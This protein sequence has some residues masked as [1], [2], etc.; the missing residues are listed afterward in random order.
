MEAEKTDWQKFKQWIADTV[1]FRFIKN[2]ILEKDNNNLKETIGWF[3]GVTIMIG[4]LFC[5]WKASSDDHR[6]DVLW[7]LGILLCTIFG[8]DITGKGWKQFSD[9]KTKREIDKNHAHESPP[10]DEAIN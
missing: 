6:L 3:L 5:I 1:S 10:L 9:N 2:L 7:F 8:L 4:S